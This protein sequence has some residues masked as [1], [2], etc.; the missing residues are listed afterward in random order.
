MEEML[1][2]RKKNYSPEIIFLNFDFVIPR[3]RNL[4]RVIFI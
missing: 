3:L 2:F 4:S 1:G